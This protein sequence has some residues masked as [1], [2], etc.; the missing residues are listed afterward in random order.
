MVVARCG[1]VRNEVQRKAQAGFSL[2]EVL[3]AMLVLIVGVVALAQVVPTALDL[4][5][6]NLASSQAVIAAQKELEQMARQPMAVQNAGLAL[7]HYNFVDQDGDLIYL[8]AAAPPSPGLGIAPASVQTGCPMA[9]NAI[10]FSVPCTV[11]GHSKKRI[12]SGRTFDIRWSVLTVY[13]N[14][15]GVV[16]PVTKRISIAAKSNV[17]SMTPLTLNLL[18]SY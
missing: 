12:M 4:D 11:P 3:V 2:V 17:R 9:G 10:D 14:E 8:G 18:V 5:A 13:G 6:R 7:G 1:R 16:R 15:R